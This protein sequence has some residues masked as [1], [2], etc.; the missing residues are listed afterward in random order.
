[1][2]VFKAVQESFGFLTFCLIFYP[3]PLPRIFEKSAG[4]MSVTGFI[5]MQVCHFV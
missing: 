1:M 4:A 5:Y 2:Q 3:T